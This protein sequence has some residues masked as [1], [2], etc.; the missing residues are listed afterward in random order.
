MV[1]CIPCI[2]PVVYV[3]LII[4]GHGRPKTTKSA[5]K[6]GDKCM[7]SANKKAISTKIK[8]KSLRLHN[9]LLGNLI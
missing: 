1:Q 4:S 9:Y 5:Y 3:S 7:K 6:I 2:T 8:I